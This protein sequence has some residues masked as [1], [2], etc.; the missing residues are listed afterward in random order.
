MGDGPKMKIGTRTDR[1]HN[2]KYPGPNDYTPRKEV[3]LENKP[4][5]GFGSASRMLTGKSGST[6]GPGAYNNEAILKEEPK[7]K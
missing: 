4:S 5:I 1:E 2:A 6:P 7:F 3:I